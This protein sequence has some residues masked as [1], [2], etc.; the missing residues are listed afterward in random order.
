MTKLLE[1]LLGSAMV[2][3]I[4]GLLTFDVLDIQLPQAYREAVWP[5]PVYL[6][7]VFGCYSLATV[8]YR[9]ATFNDCEEAA[10]ELQAQIIEARADLERKGLKF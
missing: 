5:M 8:G 7:V 9:V 10:K 6:L 1:W 3:L 2:G 4:W